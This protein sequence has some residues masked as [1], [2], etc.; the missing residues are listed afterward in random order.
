MIKQREL[1]FISRAEADERGTHEEQILVEQMP[2]HYPEFYEFLKGQLDAAGGTLY[3][4][5]PSMMTY[6]LGWLPEGDPLQ[7]QGIQICSR[8]EDPGQTLSHD[9]IDLD[10]WALLEWLVQG[11]G[12]EWSL[13]ALRKTG[14]IYKVPGAP[15]RA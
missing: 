4:R 6:S 5:G 2:G 10:I 11:V 7:M 12:G 3:F 9:I 13:D 8:M 14:A 15:L 1:E